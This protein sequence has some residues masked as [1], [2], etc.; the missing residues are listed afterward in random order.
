[1]M[2]KVT[3]TPPEASLFVAARKACATLNP[4]NPLA[5]AEGIEPL[6]SAAQAV[7]DTH[8]S[9]AARLEQGEDLTENDDAFELWDKAV[10]DLALVLARIAKGETG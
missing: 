6:V 5:V 3:M 10:C 7:I 9:L 1:M 4:S 2:D 8:K